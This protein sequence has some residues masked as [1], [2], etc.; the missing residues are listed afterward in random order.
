MTQ[1]LSAERL[2]RMH[3]VLGEM[4]AFVALVSRGETAHVE[5]LGALSFGGS[6]MQRDSMFRIA[7]ITKPIT[8]EGPGGATSR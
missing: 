7:S 4:P 5:V 3:T 1:S 6:P 8:A 2:E